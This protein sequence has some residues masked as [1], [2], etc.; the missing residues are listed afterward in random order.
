MQAHQPYVFVSYSS[1]DEGHAKSLVQYLNAIEVRSFLDRKQIDL[2]DN[3]KAKISEGLE[4]CTD[5]I[6]IASPSSLKSQWVFF[7]LGQA[8]AFRRRILTFLT[9]PGLDLPSFLADFQFAKSV[10]EIGEH[11]KRRR[12]ESARP[13]GLILTGLASTS[14]ASGA[15]LRRCQQI[16]FT[17]AIGP[18][19]IVGWTTTN[20]A[21]P[22]SSRRF[23]A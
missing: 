3:F 5:L 20:R 23:V 12:L 21:L 1:V 4:K 16:M 15:V 22:R 11:F 18:D 7:E 9:H 6:L 8:V 2:G 13:K 17:S 14:G 19:S 10:E